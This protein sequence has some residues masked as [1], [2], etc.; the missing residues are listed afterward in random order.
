MTVTVCPHHLSI[1]G[2]FYDLFVARNETWMRDDL[3]MDQT[4][5][6]FTTMEAEGEG[7][8]TVKLA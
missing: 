1:Q 2:F 5:I 4:N 6:Y 3:H 7:W 8:E